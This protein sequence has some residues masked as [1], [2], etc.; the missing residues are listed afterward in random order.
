MRLFLACLVVSSV[1]VVGLPLASSPASAE[2]AYSPPVDGPVV[3]PFRPPSSPYGPGNRGIDYATSPG[4]VV[5]AAGDGSVVFAGRI[6]LSSHVVVLHPDGLRTSY[7]FLSSVSVRRGDAVVRGDPLGVAAARLHFGVRI[8][9]DRYLDPSLLLD[10]RPPPVH[11][12]P[13]E[14]RRVGSERSERFALLRSLVRLPVRAGVAGVSWAASSAISLTRAELEGLVR[15][16][17]L[18]RYYADVPGRLSELVVRAASVLRDQ[19]NC[20]P[21]SAPPPPPPPGRRIAVL[22]AG[23]GSASGRAAVLDVDTARLGYAAGDVAQFSYRGGQAAGPRRIAGIATSR[24]GPA[25]SVGDIGDAGARL[26]KLLDDIAAAN[27]GV[28]VDLIAHSQGGLVVRSALRSGR[29]PPVGHVVTLGTPHQGADAATMNSALGGSLPGQLLQWAV[30]R[31]TRGHTDP[32]SPAAA[33]LSERSRF[34]REL[35]ELPPEVVATSIAAAGDVVVPALNSQLDGAV[36]A[37]V[38]VRGISAHDRL[39]GSPEAARELALALA[40]RGP[41]CR[42]LVDDIL[43]GAGTSILEDGLGA[44]ATLADVAN[45]G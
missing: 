15:T 2:G 27:P 40:G 16:L 43:Q 33:Q 28:P 25:D 17:D 32:W 13:V 23:F 1:L 4:D 35:P 36:N 18:A 42:N 38:P 12:V 11:L 26:R 41:T 6:G 39:P 29:A 21:G 10:G 44:V 8:A 22:V 30:R 37:I 19:R 31:G 24:Y 45:V 5:R 14:S 3:D 7:S 9:D 34:I 20:T